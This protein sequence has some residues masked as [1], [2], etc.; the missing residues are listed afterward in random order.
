MGVPCQ[1]SMPILVPKGIVAGPKVF[2]EVI[3]SI[4]MKCGKRS[5]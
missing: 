5:K 2:I 3:D 4:Q 1:I